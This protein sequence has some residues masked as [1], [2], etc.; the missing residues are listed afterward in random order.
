MS[1]HR[2]FYTERLLQRVGEAFIHR[3]PSHRASSCTE[4]PLLRKAFTQRSFYTQEAFTDTASFYRHSRL[5][6]IASLYAE[7][8]FHRE[9]TLRSLCREYFTQSKLLNKENPWTNRYRNLDAATPIRSMMSS[10]R[11]Q[12]YYASSRGA[13]QLCRSYCNAICRDRVGRHN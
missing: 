9:A 8:I 5:L 6:H 7:K 2:S 12:L 4:K 10:C 1:S 13:K 11:R 3:M